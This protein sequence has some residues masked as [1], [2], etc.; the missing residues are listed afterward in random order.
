MPRYRPSRYGTFQQKTCVPESSHQ[1]MCQSWYLGT[2]ESSRPIPGD[3]R[4]VPIVCKTQDFPVAVCR[5]AH[6]HAFGAVQDRHHH[7]MSTSQAAGHHPV[8]RIP[9]V[10]YH[11]LRAAFQRSSAIHC[12]RPPKPA[13]PH[14]TSAAREKGSEKSTCP[15]F[16]PPGGAFPMAQTGL[17]GAG[18]ARI[19]GPPTGKSELAATTREELCMG[20]HP[21]ISRF[22]AAANGINPHI[23]KHAVWRETNFCR[24]KVWQGQKSIHYKGG[25]L[26][27]PRFFVLRPKR[28]QKKKR[29][30]YFPLKF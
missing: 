12:G 5:F 3:R 23:G 27:A 18:L 4:G 20:K 2:E 25:R 30:R 1:V 9:P 17:P 14:A 13:W 11:S 10:P 6:W 21:F 28:A 19:S 26:L 8:Q 22:L 16:R 7:P 24:R 15:R 29:S